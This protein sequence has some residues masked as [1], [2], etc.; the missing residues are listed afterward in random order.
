MHKLEEFTTTGSEC[1]TPAALYSCE[2][3]LTKVLGLQLIEEGISDL[4]D[5]HT[6]DVLA[7][8]FGQGSLLTCDCEG[9]GQNNPVKELKI[10]ENLTK[11]SRAVGFR[12]AIIKT[13]A[14]SLDLL[15]NGV[16]QWL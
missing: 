2:G 11:L 1:H 14:S 13:Y 8:N 5:P 9:A 4:T 7:K 12:S 6:I 15:Y 16:N 10:R 3:A